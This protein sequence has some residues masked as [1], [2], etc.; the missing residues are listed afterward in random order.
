MNK[1][2]LNCQEALGGST[3]TIKEFWMDDKQYKLDECVAGG[4]DI[5]GEGK[6]M[7]NFVCRIGKQEF[8][9]YCEEA[10]KNG[11]LEQKYFM[12]KD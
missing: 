11:E 9:I 6:G 8:K 10:F 12:L 3:R 1:V 7:Q 2:Y 5:T 4:V